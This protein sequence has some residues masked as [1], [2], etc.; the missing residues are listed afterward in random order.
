MCLQVSG[1]CMCREAQSKGCRLAAWWSKCSQVCDPAPE[2]KLGRKSMAP[3]KKK[4]HSYLTCNGEQ[5]LWEVCPD[6]FGPPRHAGGGAAP[7]LRGVLTPACPGIYQ[8][9]NGHTGYATA[10]LMFGQHLRTQLNKLTRAM[11]NVYKSGWRANKVFGFFFFLCVDF[12]LHW[13]A[14]LCTS[15]LCEP[16]PW[17]FCGWLHPVFK[18]G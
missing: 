16:G 4:P 7:Q 15:W 10:F 8:H 5:S 14:G 17:T 18:V 3:K 6:P 9:L 12:L 1:A 13:S 2:E 11:Y